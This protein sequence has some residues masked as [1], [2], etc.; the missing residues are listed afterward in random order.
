MNFQI[1]QGD[2][3]KMQVDAIV[4]AA[5]PTLLGGGGVDGAI[6]RAAGFG[7]LKECMRLGGCKVGQAK[8]TEGYHRTGGSMQQAATGGTPMLSTVRKN[9]GIPL[10]EKIGTKRERKHTFAA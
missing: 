9:V 10:P 3:T 1:V 8:I 5:N 7:L 2:I 6:H 4:N